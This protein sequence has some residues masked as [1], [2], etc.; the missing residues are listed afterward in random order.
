MFLHNLE[1]MYRLVQHNRRL[2][3]NN[4]QKPWGPPETLWAKGRFFDYRMNI[5]AFILT[6]IR[7]LVIIRA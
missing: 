2:C 5:Y 6:N 7:Y 1:T 3:G 4:P